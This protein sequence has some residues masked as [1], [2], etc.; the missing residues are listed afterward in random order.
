MNLTV[1]Y[2]TVHDAA[3]IADISRQTFYDAFAPFNSKANMDIFMNVQFTRGRLI[4]EVGAPENIFLLAYNKDEV[5]GYAKLRNTR[6]PKTLESKNALEI[7][8]LYAMPQMVGKG[9]GKLL[10]EKSIDFAL[11]KE[12]DTL[13]LGVWKENKKAIDFYSAWGFTIFDE[14]NFLLGNDVQKDWLMKK[15]LED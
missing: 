8:R 6:H 11:E 10:M 9:V 13:W 7:A 4:L 15:K 5:A 12:K 3:L 14:C 2:A 1:R